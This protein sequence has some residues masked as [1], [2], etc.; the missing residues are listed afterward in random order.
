[1]DL[2]NQLRSFA[3]HDFADFQAVEIHSPGKHYFARNLGHGGRIA[4]A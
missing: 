2:L 1:M 3:E 4:A